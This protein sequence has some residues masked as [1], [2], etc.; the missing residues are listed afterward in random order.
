MPKV[1]DELVTYPIQYFASVWSNHPNCNIWMKTFKQKYFRIWMLSF[2]IIYLNRNI[3]FVFKCQNRHP[4]AF[5]CDMET[6]NTCFDRLFKWND[7]N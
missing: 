1:N 6:A 5:I 3:E 4:K 7:P 2:K